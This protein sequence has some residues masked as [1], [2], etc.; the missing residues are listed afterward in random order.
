[1]CP[2]AHLESKTGKR[3]TIGFDHQ[4]WEEFTGRQ[5]YWVLRQ[6]GKNQRGYTTYEKDM[7]RKYTVG[8]TEKKSIVNM[9]NY[10]GPR[11]TIIAHLL[12]ALRT[13]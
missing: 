5:G 10:F 12:W 7:V 4:L 3:L 1:M 11:S 6:T 2:T 13:Q 9:E 8:S